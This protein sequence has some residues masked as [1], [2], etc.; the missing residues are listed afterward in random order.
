MLQTT[1]EGNFER[2]APHPTDIEILRPVALARLE[3]G[4]E[5]SLLYRLRDAPDQWV[6]EWW[7]S[8]TDARLVV[9]KPAPAAEAPSKAAWLG[10]LRHD[11]SNQQFLL[12]TTLAG[13]E[14]SVVPSELADVRSDIDH[15]AA[16][17]GSVIR[18]LEGMAGRHDAPSSIDLATFLPK[19]LGLLRRV[20]DPHSVAVVID[21]SL[22]CVVSAEALRAALVALVGMATATASSER[23][24]VLEAKQ[25]QRGPCLSVE[26][27]GEGA[28]ERR[29]DVELSA[30]NR[31][32]QELAD[33]LSARVSVERGTLSLSFDQR[34]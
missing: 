20:A 33:V 25:A 17:C 30:L 21:E 6:E 7:T 26:L 32:L 22:P 18:T 34:P 29:A 13:L 10:N 5:T 15:I 14:G 16:H 9:V 28:P 31:S 24:V 2:L 27:G 3:A 4:R 8:S 19:N 12:R 1:I 23:D 11:L